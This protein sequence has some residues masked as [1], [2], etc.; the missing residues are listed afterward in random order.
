MLRQ[1]NVLTVRVCDGAQRL[2]LILEARM[3]ERR[4]RCGVVGI[5]KA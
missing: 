2:L 3:G 5:F 1:L 4:C